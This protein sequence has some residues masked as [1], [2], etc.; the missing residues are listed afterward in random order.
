MRV[1]SPSFRWT[2]CLLAW[3]SLFRIGFTIVSQPRRT[4]LSS[5]VRVDG[6]RG[7]LIQLLLPN[8]DLD[9]KDAEQW[10]RASV[11]KALELCDDWIQQ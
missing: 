9:E 11:L 4:V 7:V 10:S 8:L 5:A 1:F 3:E 2:T 6:G